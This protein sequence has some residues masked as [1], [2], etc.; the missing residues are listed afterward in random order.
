MNSPDCSA[1]TASPD[2]RTPSAPTTMPQII[3]RLSAVTDRYDGLIVDLWGVLHDGRTPYAGA[4]E[5]LRALRARGKKI[6]LLSNSSVVVPDAQAHLRQIGFAPELYDHLL[7]S[8]S[9]VDQ[10]LRDDPALWLPGKAGRIYMVGVP[11]LFTQFRNPNLALVDRPEQAGLVLNGWYSDEQAAVA[12]WQDAMR[13]WIALGLP[14]VCINPDREVIHHGMLELCPGVFAAAYEELGGKVH[15]YGKPHAPAFRAALAALALPKEKVAMI[16]DNLLTDI[17]G[18]ADF[19]LDTILITGG[20]HCAALG[21][22]WGEM[23]A[24]QA[25]AALYA[26]QGLSPTMALSHLVF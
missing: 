12:A 24:S 1:V 13:H 2:Y 3:T 5:A 19:G 8:G 26:A 25:L 17:K 11:N 15:S 6:A 21:T 14:M 4:V 23:P 10:A 22:A 18:G 20:V 7:T 16:G 9:L